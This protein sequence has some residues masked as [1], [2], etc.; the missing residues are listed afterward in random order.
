VRHIKASLL[1]C[2]SDILEVLGLLVI[3]KQIGIGWQRHFGVF[4]QDEL[5]KAVVSNHRHPFNVNIGHIDMEDLL[6]IRRQIVIQYVDFLRFENPLIGNEEP[7]HLFD[8]I[9]LLQTLQQF[10]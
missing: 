6:L 1:H 5:L 10:A 8:L 2:P 7:K 4:L 3:V 9:S